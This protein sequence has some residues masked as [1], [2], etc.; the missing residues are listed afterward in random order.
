MTEQ[1]SRQIDA[2][3]RKNT[4][5]LRNTQ[6]HNSCIN[7]VVLVVRR[8]R[9]GLRLFFFRNF[10]RNSA[11]L[12]FDFYL[13]KYNRALI[14]ILVHILTILSSLLSITI[15]TNCV[16][17]GLA[18]TRRTL[19]VNFI[20]CGSCWLH[21]NPPPKMTSTRKESQPMRCYCS[22]MYKLWLF[23]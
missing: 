4:Q 2:H 15:G 10:Y 23:C 6:A 17:C 9:G 14:E 7:V 19:R 13:R 20:F 22:V 1:R 21:W 3:T 16:I 8:P 18:D 5:T 12:L 11:L